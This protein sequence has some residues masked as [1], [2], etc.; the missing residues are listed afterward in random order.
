MIF[1]YGG[2]IRLADN[3]KAPIRITSNKT[4][5]IRM[6]FAK[7]KKCYNYLDIL[8]KMADYPIAVPK[9]SHS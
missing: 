8:P 9:M 6:D 1:L 7:K 5:G 4:D 3:N 2:I